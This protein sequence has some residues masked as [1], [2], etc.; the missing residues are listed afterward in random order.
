MV[1]WNH[2][3]RVLLTPAGHRGGKHQTLTA[4]FFTGLAFSAFLLTASNSTSLQVLRKSISCNVI[5]GGHSVSHVVFSLGD[6]EL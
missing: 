2:V 6:P 5:D 4:A 3:G 1:S